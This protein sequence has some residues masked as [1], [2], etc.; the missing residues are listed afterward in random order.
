[1]NKDSGAAGPNRDLRRISLTN[2]GGVI[3]GL[4]GVNAL[5]FHI[6]DPG[7]NGA[8]SNNSIFSEIAAYEVV[9]GGL[10]YADWADTKYPGFDLTNPAADLDGDGLSNFQEYA[11]GLNPT[12][13]TSVNPVTDT[14]ALHSAGQFSYTRTVG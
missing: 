1:M 10:T 7:P 6:M 9:Q 4:A 5:K 14:S 13:G 11:F 8:T 2:A 12:S 3:P